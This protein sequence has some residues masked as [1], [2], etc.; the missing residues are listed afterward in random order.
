[1]YHRLMKRLVL[2]IAALGFLTFVGVQAA[3]AHQGAAR[4]DCQLCALGAQ[5]IRHA[6]AAVAASVPAQFIEPLPQEPSA[7]PQATHH[8]ESPARGPPTD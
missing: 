6:P 3:H 4:D 5:A 8:C 7:K 2:A 1:M